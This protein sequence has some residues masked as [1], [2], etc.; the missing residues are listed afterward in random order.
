MNRPSSTRTFA[1]A[2]TTIEEN[3]HAP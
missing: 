3:N 2:A 1:A